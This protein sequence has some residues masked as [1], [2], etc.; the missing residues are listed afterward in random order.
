MNLPVAI[1]AGG[2]AT[3]LHPLTL[4]TPKALIPIHGQPFIK[5]QLELLARRGVQ[6]VVL[7]LGFHA[8][9]IVDFVGDGRK[10]GLRVNYSIEKTPLG[11]AG[12]LKKAEK[13]LGEN[14][15]ILYGDSYLP[16]NYLLVFEKFKFL[17]KSVLMAVYRN[18][19]RY[20]S[21]N[22][23]LKQSG[24]VTYSKNTKLSIM[25]HIDSGFSVLN[26]KAL[27]SIKIGDYS[28]LS[29]I[30]ET[31]SKDGQVNGFEIKNRFFEVGSLGGI[32]DLEAYLRRKFN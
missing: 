10:F 12:A 31:L 18:N 14:F 7:C 32:N 5:W 22:V 4:D 11:T 8:S 9:K 17:K 21:S 24:S 16:L 15:G 25:R 29:D 30:F 2:L 6:Y 3:R 27:E 20:D 19:D 23:L 1:I 26:I 13:L 28:D